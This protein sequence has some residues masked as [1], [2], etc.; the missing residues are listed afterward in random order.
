MPTTT[1]RPTPPAE[2]LVSPAIGLGTIATH[3]L[4]R[5]ALGGV[6]QN[7]VRRPGLH[8]AALVHEDDVVA[9]PSRELR[10]SERL[11]NSLRVLCIED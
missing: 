6:A 9:D 8:Y 2:G 11:N 10:L 3:K 4:R 5:T 1:R 7:L